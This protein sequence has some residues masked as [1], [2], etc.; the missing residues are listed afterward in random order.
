MLKM[1]LHKFYL[2]TVHKKQQH[3]KN[4]KNTKNLIF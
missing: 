1:R 3:K 4:N 2:P